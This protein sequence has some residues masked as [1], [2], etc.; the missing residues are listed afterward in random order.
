MAQSSIFDS[1]S[2][3]RKME[4]AGFTRQQAEAQADALREIVNERL[5]TRD[6]FEMR[7]RELEYSLIIK[8]GSMIVGAVA[9]IAALLTIMK[10]N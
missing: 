6:I 2:Y 4:A 7:I 5:A 8:L 1:L 9:V 3:A 10:Y